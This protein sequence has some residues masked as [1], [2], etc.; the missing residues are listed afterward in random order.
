MKRRRERSRR[1]RAREL[2]R[3]GA[4]R[5]TRERDG[6][7]GERRLQEEGAAP[8][9]RNG[10]RREAREEDSA[11]SPWPVVD[12]HGEGGTS[13]GAAA[14][15]EDGNEAAAPGTAGSVRGD[16]AARP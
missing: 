1:D 16:P 3:P 4:G 8:V 6:D 13:H 11:R 14:D 12:G 2:R 5:G 9:E 7:D 10:R 15:L